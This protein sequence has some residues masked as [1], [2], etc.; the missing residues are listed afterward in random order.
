MNI[1]YIIL[2][3]KTFLIQHLI[4]MT[5]NDNANKTKHFTLQYLTDKYYTHYGQTYLDAPFLVNESVYSSNS[6]EK[7][8]F[9]IRMQ[10]QSTELCAS[11][12]VAGA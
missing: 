12:C 2:N 11:N 9:M 6:S 4:L 10:H 8:I 5:R 1:I 3:V 7:L